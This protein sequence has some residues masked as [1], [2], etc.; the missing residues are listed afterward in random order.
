MAFNFISF[1]KILQ[2]VNLLLVFSQR[3]LAKSLLWQTDR[4]WNVVQNPGRQI[5]WELLYIRENE[6]KNDF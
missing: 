2:Q 3:Q 5:P 4:V 1:F 6:W